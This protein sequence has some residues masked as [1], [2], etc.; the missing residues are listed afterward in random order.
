MFEA[1]VTGTENVLGACL[2]AKTPRVVYVSTI[3]A[4]GNTR[5]EVVD[6]TYEHPGKDFTSYYEE[7][8]TAAHA[9]GQAPHRRRVAADRSSSLAA[10]TARP[11]TRRS[12]SRWT[13]S[14]PGGCRRSRSPTWG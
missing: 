11:T 8:K 1:N 13:T 9:G 3:G 12:A 2:R 6:E 4:Y 14:S 10:S 7:T 5:G